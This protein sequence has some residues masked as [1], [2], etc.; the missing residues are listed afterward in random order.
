MG[1]T[2]RR[3]AGRLS[4]W[5]LAGLLVGL[6]VPREAVRASSSCSTPREIG[7]VDGHSAA[8]ECGEE[9]SRAG[10]FR[11]TVRGP[12]RLLFGLPLDLA[13]VDAATLEALPGVGPILA[14]E[15]VRTRAVRPFSSLQDLARVPGIGARRAARLAPWFEGSGR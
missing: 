5:I 10:S 4:A 7:A 14:S 11:P 12:A 2:P 8:I 9:P 13:T 15:I 6:A 3:D 1:G